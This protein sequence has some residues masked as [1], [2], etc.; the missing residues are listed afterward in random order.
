MFISLSAGHGVSLRAHWQPLNELHLALGRSRRG[1]K[2]LIYVPP[3]S[4]K[5][6]AFCSHQS[7][8]LTPLSLDAYDGKGTSFNSDR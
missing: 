8:G 1:L 6:M 2:L 4:S 7:A 3:L 5:F